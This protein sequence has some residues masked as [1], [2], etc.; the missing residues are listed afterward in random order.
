MEYYSTIKKNEIMPFAATWL[1]L[2]TIILSEV[3]QANITCYYLYVESKEHYTNEIIYKMETD[4]QTEK[5]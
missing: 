5:N 2:G 4:S 3:S 1:D